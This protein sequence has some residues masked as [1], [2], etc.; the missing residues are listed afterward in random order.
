VEEE[1][2]SQITNAFNDGL[3]SA[4]QRLRKISAM[5]LPF[6]RLYE[7]WFYILGLTVFYNTCYIPFSYAYDIDATGGG[8]IALDIAAI[9]VYFIDAFV[10]N[11]TMLYDTVSREYIEN[12]RELTLNYINRQF[13][14]DVLAVLPLDYLLYAY[15]A[16]KKAYRIF[17]LLRLAKLPR[18]FNMKSIVLSNPEGRNKYSSMVEMYIIFIISNHLAACIMYMI[19]YAD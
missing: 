4:L 1:S 9:F 15:G 6:D 13:C 11:R 19:A 18:L 7:A 10:A 8:W 3:R 16:E 14:F 2:F 17:R 5:I 12:T